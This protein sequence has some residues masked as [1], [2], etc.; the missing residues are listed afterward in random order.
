MGE[1]AGGGE[2]S[3][4]RNG[5]ASAFI[6]DEQL[7]ST[8]PARYPTPLLT[9]HLLQMDIRCYEATPGRSLRRAKHHAQRGV[10]EALSDGSAARHCN[11]IRP[12][13]SLGAITQRADQEPGCSPL[14]SFPS[15]SA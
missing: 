9:T 5:V 6:A 10:D 15:G 1:G 14:G 12:R 2:E 11:S 7:S 3:K 4:Q 8:A 13:N